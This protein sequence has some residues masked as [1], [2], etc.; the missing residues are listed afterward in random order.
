M[1][2][3]LNVKSVYFDNTK[4][5]TVSGVCSYDKWDKLTPAERAAAHERYE[6]VCAEIDKAKQ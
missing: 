2:T 5:L 6:R 3:Q 4:H 1:L